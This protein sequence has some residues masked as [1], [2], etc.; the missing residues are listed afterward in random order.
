MIDLNQ[1]VLDRLHRE[2]LFASPNH[3]HIE[4]LGEEANMILELLGHERVPKTRTMGKL[5]QWDFFLPVHPSTIDYFSLKHPLSNTRYPMPGGAL[6]FEE[7]SLA[8]A[9]HYAE[10]KRAAE[11]A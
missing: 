7:Y 2:V 11:N 1:I 3:P 6:T 9:Q 5:L 8:Y 4:L 10:E